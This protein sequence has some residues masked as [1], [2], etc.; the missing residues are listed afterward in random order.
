MLML[1]NTFDGFL[2]VINMYGELIMEATN[3]KVHWTLYW[4]IVYFYFCSSVWCHCGL[5][6]LHNISDSFG[7]N[8]AI[9]FLGSFLQ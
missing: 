9:S 4:T 5:L 2:Q 7:L 8:I 1:T 3:H 6:I